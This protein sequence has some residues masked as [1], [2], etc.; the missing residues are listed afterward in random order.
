[1]IPGFKYHPG[2]ALTVQLSSG[3]TGRGWPK[4]G[5]Q[6]YKAHN[7]TMDGTFTPPKTTGEQI[8]LFKDALVN[9]GSFTPEE[10]HEAVEMEIRNQEQLNKN[11]KIDRGQALGQKL[12]CVKV[13]TISASGKL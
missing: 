4:I 12:K 8:K 6:H 9:T 5:T 1:M 11:I 7:V 2:K 3:P 13:K 10:A